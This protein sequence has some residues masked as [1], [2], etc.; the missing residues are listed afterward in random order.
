MEDDLS[1]HRGKHNLSMGVR[2]MRSYYRVRDNDVREAGIYSFSGQL[3]GSGLTDFML[4]TPAS[5]EQQNQQFANIH[6]TYAAGYFQDDIKISSR[7]SLIWGSATNC[8][9]RR[10]TR[11]RK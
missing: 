4:G 8:R 9:S 3:S 1:I 6:A 5:F 10:W 11:T 2:F 7:L